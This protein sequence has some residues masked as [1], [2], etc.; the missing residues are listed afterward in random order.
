MLLC[1]SWSIVDLQGCG[2]AQPLRRVRRFVT[3]WPVARQASLPFT[4]SRSL[5]RLVSVLILYLVGR[6][7][8][9]KCAEG[10]PK[11]CNQPAPACTTHLCVNRIKD[12]AI[13]KFRVIL[14]SPRGQKRPVCR[15][16]GAHREPPHPLLLEPPTQ[17]RERD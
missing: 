9:S 7:P 11:V 14:S 8:E 2:V 3:P 1:F 17:S 4:T 10:S 13:S 16:L 5:L 6:V 15:G 12:T